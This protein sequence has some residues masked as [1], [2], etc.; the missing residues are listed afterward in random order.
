MASSRKRPS[1]KK[2]AVALSGGVDSVTLLHQLRSRG[3]VSA[4]HVHH[5]LSPNADRWAAFCR[6]L[7]K[8]WGV[9]LTVRRVKVA[10]GG[11]GLEAAARE[12]RYQ[13]FS[14]VKEDCLVL[15]HHL[16]DQAETVLMNLLRGAGRRGASGMPRESQFRG[17]T[18]LRP[19]LDVPRAA[20]VAYAREHDLEWI[21][22]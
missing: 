5:G 19:L 11:K 17:K 4:I 14:K 22:D 18:V 12:A 1:G 2:L 10:K 15:A 6:R 9:P 3:P 16:D 13:V 21:E 8:R 7:C 20:I